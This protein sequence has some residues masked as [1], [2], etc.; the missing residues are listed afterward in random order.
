M[1]DVLEELA[2]LLPPE[3]VALF[4]VGTDV[5]KSTLI[6]HLPGHLLR[7]FSMLCP[8][9]HEKATEA[10]RVGTTARPRRATRRE[11]TSP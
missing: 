7:Q 3:G 4:L 2:R 9:A 1:E 5:G 8:N 11:A 6:R 10:A